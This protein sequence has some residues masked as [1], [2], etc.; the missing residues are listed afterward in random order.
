MAASIYSRYYG[1]PTVEE[2]DR[3]SLAQ[4]LLTPA[5]TFPDGLTHTLVGGETLEQLAALYYGRA[6]LWWRIADAN[7]GRFPLDWQ[8]GEI[9]A[10][11]PIRMATRTPRR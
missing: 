10:I 9:L 8:A 3:V 5:E 2:D 4:R 6:D 11:P 7:P 1:L